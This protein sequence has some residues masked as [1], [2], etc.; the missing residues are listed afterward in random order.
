MKLLDGRELMGRNEYARKRGDTPNAVAKAEKSGRIAAAV[1]RDG[2]GVFVG[3]DWRKADELWAANTDS[4]QAAR[5]G[6]VGGAQ[7]QPPAAGGSQ[8]PLERGQ[9]PV[10]EQKGAAGAA[11]GDKDPHGLLAARA[12]TARYQAKQAELDYL[13]TIGA[14]VSTE[15]MKTVGARRYRALRDRLRAV[16][17][18]I[19][20]EV[21]AERDQA[22]VHAKLAAEID[23]VLYELSDDARAEIA[24]GADERLAA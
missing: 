22:Q 12:D 4:D 16:P 18:R 9:D 15:E 6:K 10:G 7:A 11:A 20:A 3:I 19:A 8:L 13:K 17:D 24:R 1:V 14:L 21:A 5:N 2:A 23:R